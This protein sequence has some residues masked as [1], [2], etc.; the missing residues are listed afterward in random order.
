[1]SGP[2]A[3]SARSL[4]PLAALKPGD[5]FPPLEAAWPADSPSPGLL[6]VGGALDAATLRRAYAAAIFPWF[7]PGEPLLWWSPQP[8]M[9]LAV[10]RF[11]LHRSLKQALKRFLAAPACEVRF[12]SAFGRVIRACAAVPRPGQSGTWITPQM[13]AAYEELHA[14][15]LAHS[16][17]VWAKDRLLALLSAI[18]NVHG[19]DAV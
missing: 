9:A 6:A 7:A 14:Q 3:E 2:D 4:P 5:A 19:Q 15:Q 12:D 13:V 10:E 17:E 8:R 16:V 11:R 18:P 1:M